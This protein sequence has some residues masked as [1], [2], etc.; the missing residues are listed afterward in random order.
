M[1]VIGETSRAANWQLNGYH[2]ETTPLLMQT[3]NLMVFTDCMSQSNTTHKSIPILLSP[4][5]ADDYG[6]LY[7]SKGLMAA[8]NE[9]GYHTTF[10][11]NEP[12]NK[13]FNDHLAEQAQEVL[14][15]RDI[16]DGTPMDSLL[17]PEIQKALE[18]GAILTSEMELFFELFLL[19]PVLS[20]AFLVESLQLLELLEL[21]ISFE[22]L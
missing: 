11:S 9:A 2:R 5:T 8:F 14:F 22:L 1:L 4:A 16:M 12:R 19:P 15:L 7:Y 21:F 10:L 3:N 6:T 13:S 17:L 20:C 18:S